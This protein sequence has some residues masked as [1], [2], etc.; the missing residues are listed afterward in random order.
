MMHEDRQ[1][2]LTLTGVNLV[3][4]AG[5]GTGKTTLLINRLC[6]CVLVQKI[7]VEKLVALTFT[8]K[9]AAEIKT[10]FIFKLQELIELVQNGKANPPDEQTY[11]TDRRYKTL[12]LLRGKFALSDADLI[13]RAQAAL[14][15]LDRAS[16]GTIHSFCAEILKMFPLEAGLSP[17]AQIDTGQKAAQLFEER[18]NRFLDRELGVNASRAAQWKEVL[19]VLTLDDL[20]E[21]AKALSA[22]KPV[23]YD[24]YS[25]CEMLAK[26]CV[27]KSQQAHEWAQLHLPAN[28]KPRAIEK[29]LLWAEQSLLRTQAFLEGKSVPAPLE[30]V[31]PTLSSTACKGWESD[32]Q[33]EARGL[34]NFAQKITPEN[35]QLFLA[36]CELVQP[37]SQEV[38]AVYEQEGVL[39]FDDFCDFVCGR[40]PVT[41]SINGLRHSS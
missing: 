20:K 31:C 2:A 13:A 35:Q 40:I 16:I 4:E 28:G 7:P 32:E 30:N 3:V 27:Q 12:R 39:S 9:A 6:L 33:E 18:W 1:R 36:A 24:Y 11:Q 22:L 15:H 37:L 8:D 10:R 29:A 41:N 19:R 21:L 25:H 14:A 38:R 17:L 23:E 5:A 34:V 26:L